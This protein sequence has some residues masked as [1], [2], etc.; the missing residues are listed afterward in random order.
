MFIFNYYRSERMQL[1]CAWISVLCVCVSLF[2]HVTRLTKYISGILSCKGMTKHLTLFTCT[3]IATCLEVAF[4]DKRR[5]KATIFPSRRLWVYKIIL[6]MFRYP[7]FVSWYVTHMKL[8]LGAF[9]K[10]RKATISLVKS[11]RQHGKLRSY[12]RDFHGI[13]YF[14]YFFENLSRNF[15]FHLNVPRL[16]GTLHVDLCT[17]IISRRILLR[18]RN[19]SGKSCRD[20]ETRILCSVIPP[21]PTP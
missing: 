14:T 13:S 17:F 16:T 9:A 2:L 19:I 21:H 18:M 12:R 1:K 20:N 5:A 15:K 8:C 4:S 6:Y 3:F 11:V 7:Y 10:L